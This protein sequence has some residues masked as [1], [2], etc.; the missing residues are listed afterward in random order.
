MGGRVTD[1]GLVW[2]AEPKAPDA[3]PGTCQWCG[4]PIVMHPTANGNHRRRVRHK[5]DAY[6]IGVRNCDREFRWALCF[7]ARELIEKR[8]DPVCVDCGSSDR[9]W[10]ADHIV[11]LGD[12]GA[13][14]RDNL[15]RRC[16]RPCHAEKTAREATERAAKKSGQER[17]VA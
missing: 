10:D 12:G 15:A 2:L 13:H 4:E 16:R 17:L 8:G 3:P 6:E 11:P 14:H 9:P 1:R 7:S 5:G